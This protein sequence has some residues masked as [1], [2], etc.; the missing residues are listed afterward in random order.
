MATQTAPSA[1]ARGG[2]AKRAPAGAKP[3]AR[4]RLR[5]SA[6]ETVAIGPGKIALLEAVD[7]TGSI[8]AAAKRMDMSY[9]RAW[10]L[11]DELN[12]AM[13]TPAVDSANGGRQG[14]GSQLTEAGRQMID[15]YRQVEAT[16][17]AACKAD[18]GRLSGLLRR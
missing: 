1:P 5:I 8:T 15:L 14:G 4:F 10:M 16:A 6:G 3:V 2:A 11:L 7:E 18:L 9:R 12:R 13:R 17:A